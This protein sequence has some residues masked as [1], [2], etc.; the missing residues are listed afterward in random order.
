MGWSMVVAV[1]AEVC[2]V[3]VGKRFFCV[4]CSQR[5]F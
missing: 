2:P 4:L 3:I 5:I 1:Q